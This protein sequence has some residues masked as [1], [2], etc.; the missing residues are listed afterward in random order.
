M[1]IS[2]LKALSALCLYSGYRPN[3]KN[4]DIFFQRQGITTLLQ[5]FLKV[6]ND[7]VRLYAIKTL[8]LVTLGSH[9]KKMLTRLMHQTTPMQVRLTLIF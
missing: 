6:E 3:V 1:L 9:K 4:Q 7:I 5:L 8:G 2:C